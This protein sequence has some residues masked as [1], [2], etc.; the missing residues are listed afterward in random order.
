MTNFYK[1]TFAIIY[2]IFFTLSLSM[3]VY[4]AVQG[5]NGNYP[6]VVLSKGA[7]V[8]DSARGQILYKSNSEDKASLPIASDIMTILVAV[9]KVKLDT[10]VTISEQVKAVD[11]NEILFDKGVKYGMDELLLSLILSP[12]SNVSNSIAHYITSDYDKFVILMNEKAKLLGMTNT[13][14]TAPSSYDSGDL[15]LSLDD[16]SKLVRAAI[17]NPIIDSFLSTSAKPW[18]SKDGTHVL[19]NPN[20]LFWMGLEGIN[21]GTYQSIKGNG[22]SITTASREG[23]KLITIIT[24]SNGDG[25]FTD[26]V[27]LMNYCFSKYNKSLLVAKDTILSEIDFAGNPLPLASME[28]VYYTHPVG[29]SFIK[30]LDFKVKN[31]IKTPITESS[32]LGTARYTLSDDT[33]IEVNLYSKTDIKADK[34]KLNELK[35]RLLDNKDVLYF[36]LILCFVELILVI[37]NLRKKIFKRKS[38]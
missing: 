10:K 23:Q 17:N 37:N 29:N 24:G 35:I 18:I 19:I 20:K 9:E 31:D 26:T 8:F 22:N 28:D 12:T 32:V 3:P 36:I 30:S 11:S 7:M 27:N 16:F 21:G 33:A 13:T 5:V 38:A 14:F 1:K 25:A 34:N 4:A 2:L 15:K 6:P